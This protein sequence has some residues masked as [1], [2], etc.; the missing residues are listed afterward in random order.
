M[1]IIPENNT[2]TDIVDKTVG[3]LA[4]EE[5]AAEAAGKEKIN[6]T[7]TRENVEVVLASAGR[8]IDQVGG[9]DIEI[10]PDRTRDDIFH[11]RPGAQLREKI[12]NLPESPGVYMYL[13]HDVQVI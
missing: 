2:K 11:N 12:L 13:D 5:P 8:K 4:A 9:F 7:A 6:R 1:D 10:T 3:A